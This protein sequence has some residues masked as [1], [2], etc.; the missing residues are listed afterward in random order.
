M[1]NRIIKPDSLQEQHLV[2]GAEFK[3]RRGREVFGPYEPLWHSP[4]VMLDVEALGRRLRYNSVFPENLKEM[5]ILIVARH[6]N[7]PY[8][9]SVHQPIA[10]KF[11]ISEEICASIEA[12]TRPVD[13]TA[14]E[15]L[16]YETMQEFIAQKTLS[17]ATF[18]NMENKWGK[19]G[20][21]EMGSIIGIYSLLAYVLNVSGTKP[22]EGAMEFRI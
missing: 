2:A 10:V 3:N 18:S 12:R 19:R 17:P 16:I 7:Q 11:G 1:Q 21:V 22:E 9:W 20:I 8:E 5:A 4:E 13:M 14:D 15:T 6:M